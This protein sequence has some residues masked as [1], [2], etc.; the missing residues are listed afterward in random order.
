MTSPLPAVIYCRVSSTKQLTVGDGLRS[1]ERSCRAYARARAYPV[2]G[3]FED[4]ISGGTVTRVGF[5]ALLAFLEGRHAAGEET[6]VVIDDI[7]RFARDVIN[8]Y[9]LKVEVYRRGGRLESPLF[10][11]EDTPEGKFRETIFAAQAELERSQNA[12]QVRHRMQARLEQGFWTFCRFPPGYRYVRH[13]VHKKVLGLDPARS[14]LARE[15]LQGFASGRFGAV[16]DVHRYLDGRGFFA[17]GTPMTAELMCVHRMLR[18]VL[19]TGHIEYVP[20]G[21]TLRRGFHPALIS[22]EEFRRIQE[23][24]AG[25]S[26][27]EARADTREEFPLRNF[28]SCPDCGRSLTGSWSRGRSKRYAYYH[29]CNR[30][31]VSY[32]KGTAKERLEADFAGLLSRFE[33][34]DEV[35]DLA[36]AMVEEQGEIAAREQGRCAEQAAAR[37]AEIDRNIERISARA[38]TTESDA[39]FRR[40]EAEVERLA[41]ERCRLEE[42]AARAG[43]PRPE[44]GTAFETVRPVLRSPYETW[45]SGDT[46]RKRMLARVLFADRLTY[47]RKAGFGT[48]ELSLPYRVLQEV[49]ATELRVVDLTSERSNRWACLPPLLRDPQ[50]WEEF[51]ALVTEWGSQLT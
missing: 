23:R 39:M 31:C 40:L 4:G 22:L 48:V 7:K 36:R 35:L 37:L 45:V 44:A 5:D 17:P 27:P 15:A 9:A 11:F 16:A 46:R 8:H 38:G 26:Q 34:A 13:P 19:Y 47:D 3:V 12:R 28:V 50:T 43:E 25:R 18:N 14:G 1:Q 20:W 30:A 41:R 29:C 24:L 2:L 10:Q 51:V 33:T 32:G 6:V 21:V 42:T 49:K